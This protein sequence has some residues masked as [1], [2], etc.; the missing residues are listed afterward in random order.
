MRSKP[1]W[2]MRDCWMPACLSIFPMR[3]T[4]GK[5]LIMAASMIQNR[6][7]RLLN[8][9]ERSLSWYN[10]NVTIRTIFRPAFFLKICGTSPCL[11]EKSPR[12]TGINGGRE[13]C[14][15]LPGD[16]LSCI[17]QSII[18]F[19]LTSCH[20]FPRWL[21]GSSSTEFS[22]IHLQLQYEN[23]TLRIL[24]T[25]MLSLTVHNWHKGT[26]YSGPG[27]AVATHPHVSEY[28]SVVFLSQRCISFCDRA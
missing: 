18:L 12:T 14:R 10:D 28:P 15:C 2:L 23:G 17:I 13:G 24:C 22:S 21:L 27:S 8:R 4:C 26:I 3:W 20:R 19:F 25:A 7:G 11:S 9:H 5:V 1:C 6:P 16:D